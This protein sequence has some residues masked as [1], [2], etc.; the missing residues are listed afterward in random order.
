M[1]KLQCEIDR[2]FYDLNMYCI[3]SSRG[4]DKFIFKLSWIFW[5]FPQVLKHREISKSLRVSVRPATS[6]ATSPAFLQTNLGLQTRA[7]G[8]TIVTQV[9]CASHS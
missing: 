4:K 8:A 7:E 1:Q 5:Q 2:E 6:P 9:C 3:N